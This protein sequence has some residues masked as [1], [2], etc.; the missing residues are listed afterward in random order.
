MCGWGGW[1][2]ALALQRGGEVES[3]RRPVG[4]GRWESLR[5][6]CTSPDGDA[7]SRRR[8]AG[9]GGPPPSRL[10]PIFLTPSRGTTSSDG[11]CTGSMYARGSATVRRRVVSGNITTPC[12]RWLANL[13]AKWAHVGCRVA[14]SAVNYSGE[15]VEIVPALRYRC[16]L[17]RLHCCS[18]MELYGIFLS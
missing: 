10:H 1:I 12:M 18:E 16:T 6:V 13:D 15:G 5:K 4:A 9:P 7:G 2:G 3:E 11:D 8:S 14:S 17:T